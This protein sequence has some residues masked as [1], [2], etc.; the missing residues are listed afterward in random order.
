MSNPT[1]P[2]ET[3]TLMIIGSYILTLISGGAMG[4]IITRYFVLRDR[5]RDKEKSLKPD[6]LTLK[7]IKETVV[8]HKSI[9]FN[10]N[11]CE[12]LIYKEFILENKTAKDIELCEIIFEFDKD[13]LIAKEMTRSK[14][15]VNTLQKRRQ[16]SS[17]I[18]Y[19][20][21][22][23]NR[24]NKITFE[25]HVSGFSK[26]FFSAVV[27]KCTGVELEF[28]EIDIVEQPS[29]PPGRIISKEKLE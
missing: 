6:F 3:N 5:K 12:N 7:T 28:I 9:D 24:T 11:R 26:N 2:Q 29:I 18:V 4:A 15:G 14:K 10:G 23:F 22:H 16:K 27:D 1:N 13:S 21:N 17:E 20:L 8:S 25:F 19:E